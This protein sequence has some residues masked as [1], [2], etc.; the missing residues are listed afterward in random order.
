MLGQK[1]DDFKSLGNTIS[2]PGN[3][4]IINL[5]E[6]VQLA[7]D[8]ISDEL[9]LTKLVKIKD[10]WVTVHCFDHD[11]ERISSDQSYFIVEER[12]EDIY[13]VRSDKQGIDFCLENG[14]IISSE[15]VDEGG[16]SSLY[17]VKFNESL[18][19]E[20]EEIPP[21]ITRHFGAL[22]SRPIMPHGITFMD[23]ELEIV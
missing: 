12:Q 21:N 22:K 8:L 20:F 23:L 18:R 13:F 3:F 5:N 4:E 6:D 9:Q 19:V 1:Y 11:T 16:L 14:I 10:I 7:Y 15:N 17:R 2:Y